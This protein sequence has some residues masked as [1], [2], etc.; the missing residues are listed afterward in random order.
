MSPVLTAAS[1]TLIDMTHVSLVYSELVLSYCISETDM[2]T[3][4]YVRHI[5]SVWQR[6]KSWCVS[7]HLLLHR[8]PPSYSYKHNRNH[9]HK[10]Q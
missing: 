3:K 9:H 5:D 10:S 7:R 1:L 4:W 8:L 2:P 6:L